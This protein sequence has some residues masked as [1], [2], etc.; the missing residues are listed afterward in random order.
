M[1]PSFQELSILKAKGFSECTETPKT[2]PVVPKV[3]LPPPP[4]L[5]PPPPPAN[6]K[7]RAARPLPLP[8]PQ[9]PPASP[10][11]AKPRAVAAPIDSPEVQEDFPIPKHH[12]KRSIGEM[13]RKVNHRSSRSVR[14]LFSPR[15]SSR[16]LAKTIMI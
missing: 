13:W 16:R 12:A 4:A 11:K 5:P 14:S 9:A 7:G 8:P 2:Q 6:A 3:P 1:H 10:V 15:V